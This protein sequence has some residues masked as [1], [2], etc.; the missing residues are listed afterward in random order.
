M[1]IDAVGI[2]PDAGNPLLAPHAVVDDRA[3]DDDDNVARTLLGAKDE[4]VGA[5]EAGID[6]D[7]RLRRIGNERYFRARARATEQ[8]RR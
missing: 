7:Q 3:A 8:E 1:K 4:D 2:E 6:L 5:D